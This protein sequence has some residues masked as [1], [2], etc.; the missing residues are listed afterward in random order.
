MLGWTSTIV[1]SAIIRDERRR[2]RRSGRVWGLGV[3]G[4]GQGLGRRRRPAG[5][6]TLTWVVAR[7][8]HSGD[9]CSAAAT[10]FG[11]PP[12]AAGE[13]R[14]GGFSFGGTERRGEEGFIDEA[15]LLMMAFGGLSASWFS[16]GNSG[17]VGRPLVFVLLAS[18]MITI[19]KTGVRVV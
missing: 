12:R 5:I 14:R 3:G 10:C 11:A 13:V 19:G 18:V 16:E 4:E 1:S 9:G 15:S 2:R 7:M 6:D 17:F 8:S